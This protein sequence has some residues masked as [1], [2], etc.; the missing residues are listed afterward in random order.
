MLKL[1]E[2]AKIP[3]FNIVGQGDERALVRTDWKAALPVLHAPGLTMRELQVSD[4]PSLFARL[5]VEEV[6]RFIAPPPPDIAGFERFILWCQEQRTL[7]RYMCFGIVPAGLD[8]AIGLIQVRALEPTFGVAE[9]GFALGSA[10]WGNGIFPAAAQ[11]VMT[12]VFGCVGVHRLEARSSVENR[13]GN[14]AL[15]KLGA[16]REALLRN[17]FER[18]GHSHDQFLWAMTEYDWRLAREA[19]NPLVLM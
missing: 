6:A 5:A 3:P 7:G 14:G 9:W 12:F 11:A 13:R 16:K 15:E 10:F 4:A 19:Q 2:A 1:P 8:D 18:N 17:S